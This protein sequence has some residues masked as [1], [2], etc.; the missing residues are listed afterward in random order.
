LT[1]SAFIL[2]I[3]FSPKSPGFGNSLVV[4]PPPAVAF[5]RCSTQRE[6]SVLSVFVAALLIFSFRDFAHLPA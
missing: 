4:Q 6:D 1:S 2:Q 3:R 5:R